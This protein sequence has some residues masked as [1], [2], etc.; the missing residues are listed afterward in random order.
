[1]RRQIRSASYETILELRFVQS[2]RHVVER[3]LDELS[4]RPEVHAHVACPAGAVVRSGI[5][6]HMRVLDESTLDD[7]LGSD[8]CFTTLDQIQ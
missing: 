4:G 3:E 1:M 5:Q 6:V 8:R 7:D 2:L